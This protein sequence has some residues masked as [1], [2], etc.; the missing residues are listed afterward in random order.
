MESKTTPQF[1]MGIASKEDN[2]PGGFFHAKEQYAY[3]FVSNGCKVTTNIDH[4]VYSKFS[5]YGDYVHQ[6]FVSGDIVSITLDFLFQ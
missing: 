6:D 5:A 1:V 4:E 2:K 3:G